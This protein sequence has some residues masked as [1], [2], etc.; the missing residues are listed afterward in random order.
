MATNNSA[1]WGVGTGQMASKLEYEWDEN[2][3][4]AAEPP[5]NIFW[6]VA[7]K[8]AE[9]RHAMQQQLS[10]RARAEGFHG[11]RWIEIKHDRGRF[12][13]K[14][15]SGSRNVFVLEC[16]GTAIATLFETIDAAEFKWRG[17]WHGM[18]GKRI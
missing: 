12:A 10:T 14:P 1:D 17:E 3:V 6:D 18:A 5:S 15:A 7:L 13:E 16:Y 2:A 4:R 9:K 11:W 8:A